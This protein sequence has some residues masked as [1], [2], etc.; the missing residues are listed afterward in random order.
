MHFVSGILVWSLCPRVLE[1]HT[2]NEYIL[3]ICIVEISFW[4][5]TKC[6]NNMVRNIDEFEIYLDIC[7]AKKDNAHIVTLW[8]L[9]CVDEYVRATVWTKT[10]WERRCEKDVV[11]KTLWERHCERHVGRKT[12]WERRFEKYV[13]RDT[14]EGRCK[15]VDVRKI[16]ILTCFF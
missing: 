3:Q 7:A 4:S 16:F 1:L 6:R 2:V 12:L 10:L 15:K 9:R 13:V 5:I 8:V 11:R 14:W